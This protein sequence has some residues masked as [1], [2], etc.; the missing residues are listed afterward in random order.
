M[1]SYAIMYAI[2]AAYC[3]AVNE[4]GAV[5]G[6][7]VVTVVRSCDTLGCVRATADPVSAGPATPCSCAPWHDAQ[8]EA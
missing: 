6:M 3:A 5:N 1:Q 8:L 7:S 4:P 2:T